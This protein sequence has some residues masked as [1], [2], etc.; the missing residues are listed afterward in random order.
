MNK[1]ERFIVAFNKIEKYFDQQLND[2][3]YVPFH[4]AV[5]RLKKNNAIVNRYHNDL[6]EYSELRNAIV[7]ERTEM[8]YTIADPHI[9]VVE[10]IEQ[11]AEELT[12]PKLVIP[13]F[14]KTIEVIQA[15]LLLKDVLTIIRN[16][17]FTQF[18]V[19]RSKQFIGLLTDKQILH[20]IA[21]HMNGDFKELLR[22]PINQLLESGAK[23]NYRFI[24]RSMNI[25]QAEEVF[26]ETIKKHEGVDALLIT[27][28]GKSNQKLLGI[29]TP[30][31][32]IDIP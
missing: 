26:L 21:N 32:L 31:D 28:E 7:H 9:K 30:Q 24:P 10:A 15:D 20:W 18:P 22:T 4:R 1:A 5:L 6:L 13:T 17:K 27:E 16:T 25:Y 8:N 14:S 3:R 19:Y 23:P 29:L 2:T 12:A 11:I